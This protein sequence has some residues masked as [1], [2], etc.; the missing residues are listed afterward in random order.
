M[1]LLYPKTPE[2]TDAMLKAI[3]DAEE[4]NLEVND[5]EVEAWHYINL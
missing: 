2:P 1:G 5:I 4:D 3:I